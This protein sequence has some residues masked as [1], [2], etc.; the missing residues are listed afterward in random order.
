MITVT[1]WQAKPVIITIFTIQIF[2]LM[3]KSNFE[4]MQD[5]EDD[6]VE[7]YLYSLNLEFPSVLILELTFKND[8][9]ITALLLDHIFSIELLIYIYIYYEFDEKISI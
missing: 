3:P 5:A 9:F 4:N 6:K 2:W 8:A 1:S 7:R